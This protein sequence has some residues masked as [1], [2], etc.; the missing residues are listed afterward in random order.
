MTT[1]ETALQ[2]YYRLKNENGY[3]K[4]EVATNAP[5][6]SYE[7]KE[8][9]NKGGLLGGIGYTLEKLG[10][11]I[12]RSVEG[13]VDYL[14]AGAVELFG[15][16]ELADEILKNDWVDYSH[17][18]DWYNPNKAMSFIG[19]VS[20]GIGGMLPAVALTAATGGAAAGTVAFGLGA[21]GQ[22][23]SEQTKK[24]GS[25]GAKEWLYGTGSGVLETA[26]EAV[27]GGIGGSQVG[28][29]LGKNLAKST[30]GKV[31]TSF[32][33]EGLEEVASDIVNPYLQRVTGVD[34]NASVDWGAL[35]ETFLVGGTTGAVMGGAGRVMNAG[36]VGGFNNLAALEGAEEL[37]ERMSENNVRQAL[38]KKETYTQADIATVRDRVSNSLQ[39]M[40]ENTRSEFLA[41]HKRIAPFF[42][43]D[44]TVKY[45]VWENVAN[46]QTIGNLSD[47][48]YSA[49]LKGRESTLKYQP[50]TQTE[51]TEETRKALRNIELISGGRLDVVLTTDEMLT[52]DGQQANGVYADG[53]IYVNA[54]ANSYEKAMF[55][56]S[57]ELTHTLENTQ[58][59]ERLGGFIDEI[60]KAN[61][62]LAEKYDVEKYF[63]AYKGAQAGVYSEETLDYQARTEMYADFVARE[64]LGN[65][66]VV[67]RLV[68]K[69]RNIA[70]RF[71]KWVRS[72]LKRLGGGRTSTAEYKTLKKAEKLLT[73]AIE[74]AKG[75]VT[76][77]EVEEDVQTA[78]AVKA[79]FEGEETEDV[80]SETKSAGSETEDVK[81]ESRYSLDLI[82]NYTEKQYNDYGWARVNDVLSYRE[83]GNF[84]TKYRKIKDGRQKDFRRSSRDEIIVET[85]DM[86]GGKHGVNNVLVFAKGSYE[87]YRITKVIRLKIN[88]ETELEKVRD[89]IYGQ[90]TDEYRKSYYQTDDI[91]GLLYEEEYIT[92]H[93]A[94]DCLAYKQIK[95]SRAKSGRN[96]A[97]S[98]IGAIGNG[99]LNSDSGNG[100]SKRLSSLDK[101][102]LKLVE[103]GYMK[104]A[105]RMVDEAAKNA[106]YAIK[107]F[108]GSKSEFT[109]FDKGKRGSN[110]KTETSKRWF[111]AAD[112]KTANS[113]Y[114]YGVMQKIHEQ[115]PDWKWANPETL[116]NKGKLYS[117]YLK[118]DNPLIVDVAD[119][120]YAAHRETADAWMEFVEI[121]DKNGN[122]GIILYNAMDNQLDTA[123]RNSTV[124]MFRESSQAK[125]AD[126]VIYDNDGKLIPL[127]ERFN[128]KNPDIR[129]SIDVEDTEK[130]KR[131]DGYAASLRNYLHRL[132]I[133]DE[134]KSEV[135]QK[136][137]EKTAKRLFAI[138]ENTTGRTD[139]VD[140]VTAHKELWKEGF[141]TYSEYEED[142]L[143]DMDSTFRGVASKQYAAAEKGKDVANA[144]S[145]KTDEKVTV[146]ETDDT[147]LTEKQVQKLA[148][149]TKK[150]VYTK[151]ETEKIINSLLGGYMNY[152]DEIGSLQGK[153]RTEV[154]RML[155]R[156]M[157][158]AE[159]G[160]RTAMARK[161]ADYII[162]HTIMENIYSDSVVQA[163]SN[164]LELLK[165]YLHKLDLD[166]IKG[167]IRYHYG[168]NSPYARWGKRK[169]D[170][171]IPIDVAAMELE[172][173][174]FYIDAINNVDIF[175]QI[176][177]AYRK[178][179]EG[180]KRTYKRFATE[181][182][183]EKEQKALQGDMVKAILRAFDSHGTESELTNILREYDKKTQG[184]KNKYYEERDRNNLTA[185][186]LYKVQKLQEQEKGTFANASEFKRDIFKHSI[187]RLARIKYRGNLNK[188][189][190]RMILAGLLEWYDKA[191]NPMLSTGEMYNEEIADMLLRLADKLPSLTTEQ[192]EL[193]AKLEEKSKA[194][195]F[196]TLA[197]WYTKEHVGKEYSANTKEWLQKL[198]NPKEF[199]LE[200][201][202]DLENVIDYFKN[203]MEN[204][205]KVYRNGKYVEAEPLA[206][207]YV[208]M[209]QKL[210][211]VKVGW[212]RKQ[213]ETY[214]RSFA[215]PVT[216]ARFFDKYQDGF[217]TNALEELRH[218]VIEAQA[219]E[220]R[221][222]APLE[223]FYNKHKDFIEACEKHTIEYQGEKMNAQTAMLLYMTL[224]REQALRGLAYSGFK[225]KRGDLTVTVNGF[226]TE[227][228]LDIDELKMQATEMQNVLAKQFNESEK[229][230]ISIVEKIFN[231]DCKQAKSAT[232]MK[233]MGYTNISEDYYVPIRRASIA[234]NV[235][236]QSYREEIASVS[237]QS[238]NKDVVKGAQNQLF[239]DGLTGVFEK[240][241]GG[242]AQ[243]S[244]LALALDNYN[245]LFNLN[246]SGNPKATVSVKSESVNVWP[247]GDKYF[248][249]LIDDIKG[250][251][252]ST[253]VGQQFMSRIRS[254]YA[255]YQLGAN[256]KVLA[257]Q[258]SSFG[259]S[260]NILDPDCIIGGLGLGAE[261]DKYCVLAKL[262]NSE[263]TAAIAQGVLEKTTSK[264]GDVLMKPIG[265]VDRLVVKS[266]FGACQKQVEKNGGAK[267]GTEEN[268]H[269]AGELLEKVILETQQNAMATERSAAMRSGSEFMKA[270]TMFSAD[271]MKLTGRVIDGIGE[272]VVLKKMLA[273][274]TDAKIVSELKE[275]LALANKKAGRAIASVVLSALFMTAIAEMFKKLY[276]KDRD[277]DE[278]IALSLAADTFGNMLGGLPFVRDMYSY[279]TNGYEV[280]GFAYAAINDLL[281][282]VGSARDVSVSIMKGENVDSREVWQVVRKSAYSAG[283]LL[284][285]PTRN[286]YNMLYGLTKRVSPETAYVWNDKLYKGNYRSDLAKAIEN[287]DEEMISTIFG[288]M[289]NENVG[290]ITDSNTRESMDILIQ[291]GYDVIPQS[292]PKKLTYKETGKNG[293]E[294]LNEFALSATDVKSFNRVYLKANEQAAKL[295]KS[296]YY[297]KASQDEQAAAMGFIYDTY[298]DM[299][300]NELINDKYNVDIVAKNTLFAEAIDVDTLAIAIATARGIEA[301]VDKYGKTIIGSK[302]KKVQN[303]VNSLRL[304]AVQKYMIMGYLGYTNK[305]GLEQVKAYINRLKL[306]KE[307]KEALLRYS[308]YEK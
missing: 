93:T 86:E 76:L 258:F 5:T 195:D 81:K 215:D 114:P 131:F 88:N 301:D 119:Y 65:E 263:N 115:H 159:P 111:F 266:L 243:Y 162:Q 154:I 156:G 120:D 173:K 282:S 48:T 286:V 294:I 13:V 104:T 213:M 118:I 54:K 59:Y 82:D 92:R 143:L 9:T 181:I 126:A 244:C 307:Q 136:Y 251:K 125:S 10:L 112:K 163:N 237:D 240:H 228:N 190:T 277:E 39:K 70:V 152:E 116:K 69:E 56:V 55:V 281:S 145:Q 80:K 179:A 128:S 38:G 283:Q 238:F 52:A 262:R 24:N 227:E 25:A 23:T 7:P 196:K 141:R 308:G 184:W 26:I 194:Y 129:Y 166:G 44:G 205:N 220:D 259:A 63:N 177:E 30:A 246:V 201:L 68:A 279:F 229:Q 248:S 50:A 36:K 192:Y 130:T 272:V 288:L 11:G 223:E 14:A 62:A 144:V 217:F 202:K 33:G 124:Y 109:F 296:A 293:E 155:W 135:V 66:N 264:V 89:Y 216:V 37:N 204:Y 298:Y 85:N 171:G 108:H 231:E 103:Y 254:G 245:V 197:E 137:G 300:K 43:A 200:E 290:K 127:S 267:V 225:F 157:N 95:Q 208:D 94:H 96:D 257:T 188:S 180:T 78:K 210:K 212:G 102:Y 133:S 209:M 20:G 8:K 139:S 278:N 253:G 53:V 221:M 153:T 211:R 174:G 57:H 47:I 252:K 60:I 161:V 67:R 164:T 234:Y 193:I 270:I 285:I 74:N 176:D 230:Y 170:V 222:R 271:S 134:V 160:K 232:D 214:L 106:G 72:A 302:K 84:R 207:K 247:E 121:A 61:P 206:Q 186:V 75:G 142:F 2:R 191:N 49:S 255:K 107:A 198:A 71:L 99:N 268:K 16:D 189:G 77:D 182:I 40:D 256:L 287:G 218:G 1:N 199:S 6:I 261:V 19:D 165:P 105:Q 3:S 79:F 187:G 22:A 292:V 21:A 27:S 178:A 123:A 147:E 97:D 34:K 304:T 32:I 146:R 185:R 64:I 226:A 148:E 183:G 289:L 42:N 241:V 167:D 280:E 169:G 51:S 90:E 168:D 249:E 29:V 15:N 233:R 175:L 306:T 140:I 269:A 35:P 276:N 299:A 113:Y 224:K 297:K 284:G 291:A 274:E 305:N 28:K 98:G 87:D 12:T 236:K 110:T 101:S 18:D 46:S 260:V 273:T 58:E 303:F 132:N 172:E 17:A 149:Y 4:S 295:V 265:M 203:F 151:A 150:K 91:A 250:I 41:T 239:I 45:E 122:D 219:M 138:W 117:L 83:N 235:E 100:K 31:A 73:S 242:I 158:T 275:R